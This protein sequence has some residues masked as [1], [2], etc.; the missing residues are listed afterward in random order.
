[1]KSLEPV[2]YHVADRIR[3][4]RKRRNLSQLEMAALTGIKRSTIAAI[5]NGNSRTMLHEIYAIA[6]AFQLEP[7]D[8]FLE[9]KKND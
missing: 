2:Y 5:E 4:L 9:P 7:T 3:D 1:M 6:K 8:I